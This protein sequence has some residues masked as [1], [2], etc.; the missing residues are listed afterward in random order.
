MRSPLL[1]ALALAVALAGCAGHRPTPPP[2]SA[3]IMATQA[4]MRLAE[5]DQDTAQAIAARLYPGQTETFKTTSGQSILLTRP[6]SDP[7]TVALVM[8]HPDDQFLVIQADLERGNGQ[9][10]FA[11]ARVVE[12]TAEEREYLR[13]TFLQLE[14]FEIVTDSLKRA[15]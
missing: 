9:T 4:W 7:G 5:S 8:D 1:L 6:V 10:W 2:S 11:R 15:E 12:T 3:D 13:S 14:A